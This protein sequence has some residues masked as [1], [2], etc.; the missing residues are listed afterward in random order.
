MLKFF[1]EGGYMVEAIA[2]AVM[3]S[4]PDVVFE[5]A[6]TAHFEI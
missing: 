2:H 4:N 1:A 6:L 5:R 3:Q